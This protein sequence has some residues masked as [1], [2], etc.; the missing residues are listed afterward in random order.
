MMNSVRFVF[1][2]RNLL[3]LSLS[4]TGEREGMRGDEN[5]TEKPELGLRNVLTRQ[6]KA[7]Q[8]PLGR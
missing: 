4:P 5:I 7:P 2:V 3:T 1:H 6:M 8:H